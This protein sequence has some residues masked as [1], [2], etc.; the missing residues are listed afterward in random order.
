MT[1]QELNDIEKRVVVWSTEVN[2]QRRLDAIALINEI[3]R[4]NGL[5]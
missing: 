4:L 1:E 3:R 2:A 5:R